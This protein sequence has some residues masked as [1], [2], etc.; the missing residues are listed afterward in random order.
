MVQRGGPRG[1]RREAGERSPDRGGRA[2]RFAGLVLSRARGLGGVGARTLRNALGSYRAVVETSLAGGRGAVP[3]A[4]ADAIRAAYEGG[5]ARQDLVLAERGG[6]RFAVPGGEDYPE[7]LHGIARPPIG[8]YVAGL[9][10]ERL[11]PALAIV[12]TRAATRR[13]SAVARDLAFDAA[14]AGL[15]VVSGLARGIDTAAHEGALEAGGATVAVLGS[16]LSRI[17]PSENARLAREIVRLGAIVSEY[18]MLQGPRAGS[19]PARNRI[20]AG[21]SA[22]VVVVEAGHRSGAL[23]TAARALEEG[24][25]V[26]AVPG[27]VTEPL[28]RGPNGLIKAGAALVEGIEDVLNELRPAWGPLWERA[29]RAPILEGSA[30]ADADVADERPAAGPGAA[31]GSAT[32]PSSRI[33]A[34]L[35][36]QPLSVDELCELT[37]LAAGVVASTLFELELAGQASACPGARYASVKARVLK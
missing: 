2:E 35:T 12:G 13:G 11:Q 9:P 10:L 6:A 22:G 17:Y 32:G 7:I 28:S 23:I 27:P 1:A 8:F 37:G 30:E 3:R 4:L 26:F 21:L 18:P 34:L 31:G 14:S 19:F 5:V 15:T 33:K 24:R 29:E 36:E 20:I 25:E 16:G